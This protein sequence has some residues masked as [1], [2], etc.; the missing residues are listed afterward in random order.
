MTLHFESF[1]SALGGYIFKNLDQ[2][3]VSNRPKKVSNRPKKV[4][5]W[6]KKSFK[7]A[8]KKFQIG[9]KNGCIYLMLLKYILYTNK[10]YTFKNKKKI[11]KL[12]IY[13]FDIKSFYL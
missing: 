11:M 8:Q 6:P 12:I 4:S 10:S 9:P 13:D 7:S 2:K 3:K 5:N 1:K